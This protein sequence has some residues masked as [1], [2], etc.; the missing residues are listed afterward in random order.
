MCFDACDSIVEL[1][2]EGADNWKDKSLDVEIF[3]A[4]LRCIGNLAIKHDQG[5]SWNRTHMRRYEE[6]TGWEAPVRGGPSSRDLTLEQKPIDGEARLT[7]SQELGHERRQI[8]AIYLA[9]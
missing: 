2:C 4:C 1:A 6:L 3:P 5:V 9:K 8:T 7:I